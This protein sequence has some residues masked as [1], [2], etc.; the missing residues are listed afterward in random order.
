M[1]VWTSSFCSALRSYAADGRLT[2]S[3][4]RAYSGQEEVEMKYQLLNPAPH[5]LEVIEC[6]R[7]VILAGGT[8]SPVSAENDR[9]ECL[10]SSSPDIRCHKPAVFLASGRENH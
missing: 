4:V 1:T 2:F 7:S 6:A 8:M 3:L 9:M 5:F 10:L